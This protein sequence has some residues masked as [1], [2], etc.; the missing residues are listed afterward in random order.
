MVVIAL[1]AVFS[2]RWRVRSQRRLFLSLC[3]AA[4]VQSPTRPSV[5]P[6]S[7]SLTMMHMRSAARVAHMAASRTALSGAASAAAVRPSVASASLSVTA[8]RPLLAAAAAADAKPAKAVPTT[9]G[10]MT[11]FL[12]AR[13]AWTSELKLNEP[14]AAMECFRVMDE[15]AEFRIPD[16]KLKHDDDALRK[17]YKTMVQLNEMDKI[18]YDAQ[19]V[20]QRQQRADE[21]ARP[22]LCCS[23]CAHGSVRMSSH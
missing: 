13:S 11:N 16:Y 21:R 2:F 7:T 6:P 23:L 9:G 17:M 12:G 20:R 15:R 10:A 4:A 19:S 22:A 1:V 3:A 8:S 14:G 5:H 18:F